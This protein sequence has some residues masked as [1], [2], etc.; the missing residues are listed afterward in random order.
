MEYLLIKPPRL[1][2]SQKVKNEKDR[3]HVVAHRDT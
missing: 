1:A 2:V 3:Q